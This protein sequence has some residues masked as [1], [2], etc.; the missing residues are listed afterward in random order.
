MKYCGESRYNMSRRCR[1]F[2]KALLV[3]IEY[4]GILCT[5]IRASMCV[6]IQDTIVQKSKAQ[7]EKY[8]N[9]APQRTR[10]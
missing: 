3:D 4:D 6:Q 9:H 1:L 10:P 8:S 7:Q 5:E 2:I